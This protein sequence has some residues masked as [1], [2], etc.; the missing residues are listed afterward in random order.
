MK[1]SV[2]I[3]V[4]IGIL[5]IAGI[6]WYFYPGSSSS[7][8]SQLT[9]D[10]TLEV[11]VAMNNEVPIGDLEVDLWKASSQGIPDAGYN[12]TDSQGIVIFKIPAGEYEIG[13]NN[14]NF[15]ENLVFPERTSVLVEE[16]VPASVTI[17]IQA[18]QE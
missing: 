16:G 2:A 18:K 6:V 17:L 1:K 11:K 3:G 9:G 5:I 15:P 14:V 4:I 12:Y 13:F 8:P 10:E 7:Q